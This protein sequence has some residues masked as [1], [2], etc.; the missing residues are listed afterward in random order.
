MPVAALH[1]RCL[2]ALLSSALCFFLASPSQAEPRQRPFFFELESGAAFLAASEFRIPVEFG[3]SLSMSEDLHT[4]PRFF[5]RLRAGV[6]IAERH[7]VLLLFAPLHFAGTGTLDAPL[8]F[9]AEEIPAGTGVE[10][11]FRVNWYRV[12]YRYTLFENSR[13]NIALGVGGGIRDGSIRL[14]YGE[15][16]QKYSN[17][18][19]SPLLS[20]HAGLSIA[21][22][23][24]V[25]LDGDAMVTPQR[26][27]IDVM[28][29]LEMRILPWVA[30]R[31]G[32]RFVEGGGETKEALTSNLVH[33]A[34]VGTYASF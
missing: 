4:P 10:A 6:T 5:Y 27:L 9:G 19:F 29:A 32:Y 31:L 22:P 20:F 33:Y 8:R 28:A 18:D 17:L 11:R 15:G 12:A 7:T 16:G 14:S 25:V 13:A 1:R 3:S 21:P 2:S 30:T 23:F 26:R 34:L 24:G